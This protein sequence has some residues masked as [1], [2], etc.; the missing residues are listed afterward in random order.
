MPMSSVSD[1]KKCAL[2]WRDLVRL[3]PDAGN[4]G[5]DGKGKMLK[6]F[7]MPAKELIFR[8]SQAVM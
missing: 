2:I 1:T 6:M 5:R 4:T 3:H 7:V 8:H